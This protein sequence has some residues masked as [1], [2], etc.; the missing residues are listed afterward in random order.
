MSRTLIQIHTSSVISGLI[1]KINS[2]AKMKHR[3]KKGELKELFISDILRSYLS[4]QFNI[5][6]GIIINQA[7]IQSNQT[8]VIIYDSR[9][10]PPFIK[11]ANLGVFPAECVLAKIEVK[12]RLTKN[13]ILSAQQSAH[14]L[15][16][17]IYDSEYSIY[18]DM[19]NYLPLCTLIGFQGIGAKVLANNEEGAVWLDEHAGELNAICFTGKFSWLKITDSGWRKRDADLITHEE[20]KRFL[21]AFLDN[22]RTLSIK[23]INYINNQENVHKDWLGI[24]LRDQAGIQFNI[25]HCCKVEWCS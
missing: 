22:I 23:R 12:S 19:G 10:L 5:G 24:Y 1:E 11:E 13:S 3:L 7:G 2:L 20:T 14:K 8:D 9:I 16:N 17:E 25:R 15:H 21:A 18:Q 6:S 4:S